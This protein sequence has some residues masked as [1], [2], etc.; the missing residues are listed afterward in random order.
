MTSKAFYALLEARGIDRACV[1]FND[2]VSDDVFCVR[3]RR[4]GAFDVFYRE[5]GNEFGLKT[6]YVLADALADLSGRLTFS[7]GDENTMQDTICGLKA[8]LSNRQ[9]FRIMELL[10]EIQLAD[11]ELYST[12]GIVC[13]SDGLPA[14]G[15]LL[16]VEDLERL[17]SPP[18]YVEEMSLYLFLR[19]TE[20]RRLKDYADYLQSGCVCGVMYYDC[21]YLEVYAKDPA[22]LRRFREN[23]G[24]LQ[25]LLSLSDKTEAADGRTGFL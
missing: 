7:P 16:T 6:F 11:Y 10:R 17:S 2:S 5:R 1:R 24:K 25:T 19:G 13:P 12:G 4:D 18:Y 20:A 22:L 8:R 21:A 9:P 3:A 23:V 14:G 15:G